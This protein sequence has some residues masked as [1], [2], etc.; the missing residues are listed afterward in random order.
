MSFAVLSGGSPIYLR[1]L[2]VCCIWLLGVCGFV[3]SGELLY[4]NGNA[5]G[6][7]NDNVPKCTHD[8]LQA[9]THTVQSNAD[10][11]QVP[12][13]H[14]VL[15]KCSIH[16]SV[17]LHT[18]GLLARARLHIEPVVNRHIGRLRL[19]RLG[20]LDHDR[21]HAVTEAGGDAAQV[22]VLRKLQI[23]EATQCELQ[24][25]NRAAAV[26][27]Q[28]SSSTSN[29]KQSKYTSTTSIFNV[30]PIRRLS[31]TPGR[32]GGTCQSG[33]PCGAGAA[34]GPRSSLALPGCR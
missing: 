4:N 14:Q 12:I 30:K 23:K 9:T 21:Q 3:V 7:S 19:C 10:K 20:A 27:W 31:G 13:P 2:K 17:P 11:V 33:A 18:L 34:S 22:C 24:R 25:T 5:E 26:A 28:H 8:S 6:W 32:S 15:P 1:G 29:R 16:C